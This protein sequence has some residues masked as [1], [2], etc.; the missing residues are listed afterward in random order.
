MPREADGARE[1]READARESLGSC[2]MS[3][4]SS[5]VRRDAGP[6]ELSR[7]EDG[8]ERCEAEKASDER[9]AGEDGRD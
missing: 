8:R 3:K 1:D 6:D 9:A 5:E 7:E 2:G 4:P